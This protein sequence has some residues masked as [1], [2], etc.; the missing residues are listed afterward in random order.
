MFGVS[1]QDNK[2]IFEKLIKVS[3]PFLFLL[4][5]VAGVGFI[6]LYS[7]AGGN[8]EPWAG[9]HMIRFGIGM[10]G[11]L[12]VALID[13]RLWL[14]FSYALYALTLLLLLFVEIKG[15]V[16]MGAQR[17]I[18]LGFMQLQPSEIMKI[19]AVL[20]LA[21]FFNGARPEDVKRPLFLL[22]PLAI[23]MV[24][25]GLV[26]LQPDLGTAL[27][28][29]MVG[30]VVFFLAGVP[31]WMFLSV[32]AAG[33]AAI[34]VAWHF[35]HDYQKRRVM[36]F[37]DPETDPLGAGYHITQSKIALGSGG[38]SG[39]GFL[40]GT[41]SNLNFL[42]EKQTDFIFTLF[43]EE[44]GLV[45]G[46]GLLGLFVVIIFYGTMMALSSQNQF[47]RLLALGLVTNFFLYIFI[48]IGMVMGLLPVV[49]V[50]LPLI[51]NGGSV[52]MSILFGFGLVMS[53]Y[54]HRD[55]KFS[56]RG[57]DID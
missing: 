55:V 35:L 49:G 25:V 8:I 18:N 14:R 5:L 13:I 38:I 26:L 39:K 10:V 42:P 33:V 29:V 47:G 9:K 40:Q 24:P 45:G 28:I 43:A 57:M 21:R 6:S 53:V 37:I 12:I 16:G 36:T 15:Q 11:L 48:N 52:M 30:G 23:V 51:S 7:A 41:Q 34:P 22:I 19:T 1:G 54:V 50:P 4:C 27:K 31:V 32:G 3:W 20:A 56:R 2:T 17:W 44:W 46:L